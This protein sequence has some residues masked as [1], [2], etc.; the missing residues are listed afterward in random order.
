LTLLAEAANLIGITIP[1]PA[2]QSVSCCCP[3]CASKSKN[4]SN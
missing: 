3:H 2:H 4:I 1:E